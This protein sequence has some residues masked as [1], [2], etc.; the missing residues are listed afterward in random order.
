[1]F[2]HGIAAEIHVS[3]CNRGAH[4][5]TANQ[6][7]LNFILPTVAFRHWFYT[8]YMNSTY[9]GTWPHLLAFYHCTSPFLNVLLIKFIQCQ[10]KWKVIFLSSH[11]SFCSKQNQNCIRIGQSEIC[12]CYV[13]SVF[14]GFEFFHE[15]FFRVD[16]RCLFSR[17][18]HFVF[19]SR[20]QI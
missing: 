4:A 7:N 16:V 10:L 18:F 1:M 20:S 15:L 14:L 6:F 5:P 3:V 2:N 8:L 11:E 9:I 19:A 13:F 12:V 17:T